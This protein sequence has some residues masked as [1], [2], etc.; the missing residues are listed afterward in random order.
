MSS[1]Y[2]ETAINL[3]LGEV[4]Y[5][6]GENKW[7]KYADVLDKVDF[8]T[9]CGA[10][11]NLDFCAVGLCWAIY[12]AIIWPDSDEDPEGAKW[13]AHFFMYQSDT[14]DTAAVVKYLY[15]FFADNNATTNN[16]QRGDFAIF[17]KSNGVM[18]HCGMVT[19]WDWD[20]N[21]I[22][23]TEFN[24]EGGQVKTHHYSFNDIGGKI[25]TFC[26]PRYDG[27]SIPNSNNTVTPELIEKLA[28]QCINGDFGN[29]P[30]RKHAIN[31][32]GYGNIYTKVQNRV[33]MILL[34][35]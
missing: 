12:K 31:N 4:G 2:A 17:Q 23:I 7:N 29:Y 32:L 14:C 1:C 35:R 8:F 34:G 26:R 28:L 10:K 3:V 13:G 9:G 15:Q 25:K 6:C 20:N 11:Q 24:T 5:K 33:N 22:G 19:S 16:P 21:D 30:F 27:F 18:Y